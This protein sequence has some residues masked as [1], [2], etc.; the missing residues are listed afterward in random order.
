MGETAKV[1][2][3]KIAEQI[4]THTVKSE[5]LRIGFV[6]FSG[7]VLALFLLPFL[8]NNAA[9][10]VQIAQKVN[11]N[12]NADFAI[13]GD[14]SVTLLPSPTIIANKVLLKN[15]QA[16]TNEADNSPQTIYDLYAEKVKIKLTVFKFAGSPSIHKLIFVNPVIRAHQDGSQLVTR[17]DK[18]EEILASVVKNSSAKKK[19]SD[20][21]FTATLFSISDVNGSDFSLKK[22]PTIEVENGSIIYY[23]VL[24][25]KKEVSA[26]NADIEIDAK[27]IFAAGNF[28]SANI[29]SNFKLIAKFNSQSKSPKSSFELNSPVAKISVTG[30]FPSENLGLFSSE[31]NGKINAEI[32]E[33]RTFYKS[34]I[35]GE[36]ALSDKLQYSTKPINISADIDGKD[37]DFAITNL[38]ISSGLISGKGTIDLNFSDPIPVIDVNLDLENLDLDDLL[39]NEEV[40]VSATGNRDKTINAGDEVAE[41]L[42]Q[43]GNTPDLQKSQLLGDKKPEEKASTKINLNLVK[44]IK[45]FDLTAEIKVANIKFLAGEIKE[46]NLYASVSHEGEIII[47]PLMFKLPGDGAF[48]V[49]GVIDNTSDLPKFLGK[50]DVSGSSL[51]EILQWLKIESQS[52]KFENLKEYTIYSDIFLLPNS[53]KF[54]NFYLNLN[55]DSSEIL[56][57]VTISTSDKTS[58]IKSR[59]SGNKLN[60]DDYF[61]TSDRSAY[62]TPGLLVRKL[63]WLNN[64]STNSEFDLSFDQL[65]YKGETFND[66]SMNVK[67]NR[68]YFEIRDLKMNSEKTSLQA[69]L[70]VDISDQNP[71]FVLNITADKFHYETPQ[72]S[73]KS[74]DKNKKSKNF[75]DQFY[76]L[77]SLEGFNGRIDLSFVDLQL[78]DLPVKNLK[79]SSNMASG[80]L[81]SAE[82]FSDLFGGNLAYKGMINLG[83]NK[84]INGNLTL[85]N[86]A[87][88]E[89]LP[90]LIGVKN[91]SGAVN[92]AASI[93][94]SASTKE[95]FAQSLESEINF[96][97]NAPSISG[98][99]LNDLVLKMFA[100]KTNAEELRDPEKI[101]LN[102][103]SVTSF[104]KASGKI[105]INVGG[106]GKISA[107]TSGALLNG[108]LSGTLDVAKNTANTLFST[109]F[110]TGTRQKHTTI[111]VATNIGGNLDDLSQTIN[112]E[113]VRQYL[114]LSKPAPKSDSDDT[115]KKNLDQKTSLLGPEILS[116]QTSKIIPTPTSTQ[117]NQPIPAQ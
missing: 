17:N 94:D 39:S 35:G 41:T 113:Q 83:L 21:G 38:L 109:V 55:H 49:T 53:T 73:E 8:F 4:K 32:A 30:N 95:G 6:I 33:V 25:K 61:L 46:A 85:K 14:V 9:L 40:K 62:F 72:D 81:R 58:N 99:G 112:L 59:F 24:D 71:Q 116:T 56:G 86:A 111:N 7:A 87:L 44:A 12:T 50:F 18:F 1:T 28:N 70:L 51:K 37:T 76:A 102:P 117:L 48:R 42:A 60:V 92:V 13:L 45:N 98:Y 80:S 101:L 75:L 23:D 82:F 93:T 103:N 97:I 36:S 69:N 3:S 68:G 91:I 26:I 47:S 16:K 5:I 43:I 115:T 114:G 88:Q 105:K 79:L 63:L 106:E 74:A 66:Q 84:V 2:T 27:R 96:N 34:Y 57:E 29:T 64:I 54:S 100:P 19:P 104:K 110:L 90:R 15:Y 77:P 65:I 10:K 78:D 52:L 89:L 22:S 67:L 31:F 11:Q 108:V 20:S 107:S